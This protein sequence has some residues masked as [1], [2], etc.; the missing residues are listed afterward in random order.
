MTMTMRLMNEERD[1]SRM[2]R[3]P[4]N[5][6]S[7]PDRSINDECRRCPDA[8]VRFFTS[9]YNQFRSILCGRA[10]CL[11]CING[12]IQPKEFRI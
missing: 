11:V 3:K 4:L 2:T 8:Q 10:A 6:N 1:Y 12:F 9:T 7:Y 5:D